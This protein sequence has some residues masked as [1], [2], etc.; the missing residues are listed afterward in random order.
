MAVDKNNKAAY[1]ELRY[2]KIPDRRLISGFLTINVVSH[3]DND[4]RNDFN[5]A[6]HEKH[7]VGVSSLDNEIKY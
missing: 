7:S 6:V 2:I 4:D 5:Q 3:N 1:R